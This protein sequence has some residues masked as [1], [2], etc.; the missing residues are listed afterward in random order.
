MFE[1]LLLRTFWLFFCLGGRVFRE[2][3]VKVLER[4][5]G[6]FLEKVLESVFRK[7]V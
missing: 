1:I 3:F 7:G 5:L 4:C 2:V 6:R